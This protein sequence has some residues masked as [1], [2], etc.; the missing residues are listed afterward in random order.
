M[1]MRR[2]LAV[3]VVAGDLSPVALARL[4]QVHV[5]EAEAALAEGRASG[6]VAAD[7]TIDA[8]QRARLVADLPVEEVAELHAS[9]ARHLIAAGP[10]H[11][12][13]A[14]RHARAAGALLPLEELVELLDRAGR[15]NLALLDHAAAYEL[16]KAA[17]EFDTAVDPSIAGRRVH[18]LA[19]AADGL[20]RVDECHDLLARA[21][22]L[23]GMVDDIDLVVDAATAHAQPSDWHTGN[24]RTTA[25]LARAAE[26][27]LTREQAVRVDAARA[28]AEMRIPIEPVDGQ[29][30][31]WVTRP[32]VAQPL[33]D[34]AV[35]AARDCAPEVRA[36]A[37]SAW[38]TVHR[39]PDRLVERRTASS[40]ALDLAQVARRHDLQVEGAVWLAVDALESADRPL[41]DEALS[42]ARWVAERDGNPRL[43][44]RATTLAA[45][46]A[47]LDGDLDEAIRL[48]VEA[49]RLAE[50]LDLPGWLGAEMLLLG[51]EVVT[52]R[53]PAEMPAYL[54]D[55]DS[56]VA[57][58][59]I[60]R[61]VLAEIRARTGDLDGALRMARS[62][63]AQLDPEASYLVLATRCAAVA[64][65]TGSQE[66]ATDLVGVLEPWRTRVAIDSHGWWCDGP[67]A[68]WL[69]ELHQLL[70]RPAQV[71][72]DL[73][74]AEP[75]V[76]RINDARGRE[77]VR[78]LRVVLDTDDV[79]SGSGA[80]ALAD[81]LTE[82]EREVL[83]LLVAGRTN[84]QIAEELMFSFGT[85]RAD[86]VSIYRK[87]GVKGR[88]DA[89]AHAVS[90]GIV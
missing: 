47:H 13:D 24:L 53:D 83:T 75:V 4:G 80:S 49:R 1:D 57:L 67:V 48:R 33:A 29:Q 77:R 19:V 61:A 59:P 12:V 18:D 35:E 44:W 84:R 89:V 62:S 36:V 60:G 79:T 86:T 14:V 8:E 22:L 21:V 42:V 63:F 2:L 3:G 34:R 38:R 88:T 16:L 17:S 7:G 68:L 43:R 40:T 30:V 71:V 50:P 9:I 73:A 55:E 45:G 5:V 66:F 85:I 27:P 76:V 31:A 6:L 65:L 72:D 51:E 82:R 20:G 90:N 32:A 15:M 54:F 26:L 52:R 58:N 41:F 78:S 46:A 10:D 28:L 23:G 64:V 74:I 69:A 56:P 37:L 70:G 25:L 87:L 81:E 39:A 11:V